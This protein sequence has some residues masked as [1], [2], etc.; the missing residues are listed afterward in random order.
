MKTFLS[1]L[2]ALVLLACA[3]SAHAE[4]VALIKVAGAINPAT[5]GYIARGIDG[6]N[7]T[8]V[9]KNLPQSFA[10]SACQIASRTAAPILPPDETPNPRKNLLCSRPRRIQRPHP[11]G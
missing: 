2:V 9:R 8:V 5:S 11:Y 4:K 1:G 6:D 10:E 3:T 7:G